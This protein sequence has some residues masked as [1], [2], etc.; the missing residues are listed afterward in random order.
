MISFYATKIQ[1]IDERN[2][3]S[4]A[5]S[6][7]SKKKHNKKPYELR[8]MLYI[9]NWIGNDPRH[10]E[11]KKRFAYHSSLKTWEIFTKMRGIAKRFA[12]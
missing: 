8:K 3:K 11:I 6:A 4:T 9:R 10:F 7:L 5:K 12:L 1:I 2:V